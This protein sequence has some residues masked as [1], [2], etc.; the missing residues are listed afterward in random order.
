MVL[1]HPRIADK[2]IIRFYFCIHFFHRSMVRRE[3]Y[4]LKAWMLADFPAPP[5]TNFTVSYI[6]DCVADYLAPAYYVV[7]P[8]DDYSNNSIYINETTDTSDISYFTTLAHE[9]FPGHLYQT[10]MTYQSASSRTLT[11]QLFRLC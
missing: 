7:T 9:G 1:A 6:D 11:A 5:D 10:V 4:C 8:I 2:K 3:P